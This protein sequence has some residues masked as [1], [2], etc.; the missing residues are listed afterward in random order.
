MSLKIIFDVVMS[1]KII[2]DEVKFDVLTPCYL[3][4]YYLRNKRYLV[5]NTVLKKN[6]KMT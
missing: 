1:L 6:N 4:N 5:G 3:F 2:F